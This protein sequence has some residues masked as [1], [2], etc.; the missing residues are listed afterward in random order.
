MEHTL[1]LTH[2]AALLLRSILCAPEAITTLKDKFAA[3]VLVAGTLD[4][5]PTVPEEATVEWQKAGWKDITITEAQRD[6][7]KKAVKWAVE[8]GVAPIGAHMNS[9]IEQLGLCE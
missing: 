2:G 1:K 8:K 3:G 5:L 6:A 7:A 4:E 9:L